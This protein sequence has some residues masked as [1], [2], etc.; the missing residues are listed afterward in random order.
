M[1]SLSLRK[2]NINIFIL[3][4]LSALSLACPIL[5][6]SLGLKGNEFLPIFFTLSIG[7]YILNPLFLIILSII[8]PLMNYFITNM[9][10]PP[11]LYF[12]ILEGIVFSSIVVLLRNKNISFVLIALLAFISARLSSFVLTFIFDVSINDWFNGVINS[13]KG[14]IV[15]VLFSSITYLI[16]KNNE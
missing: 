10:M 2:S 6:H 7:A 3:F 5:T 4:I 15:N 16:L 8:S 1:T 11:T 12:L 9:P 13:Y 14:I